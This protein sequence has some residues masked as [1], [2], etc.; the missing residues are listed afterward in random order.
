MVF[1]SGAASWGVHFAVKPKVHFYCLIF[2]E[3]IALLGA[4]IGLIERFI[5]IL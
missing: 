3:E 5:T 2:L 1:P 4:F